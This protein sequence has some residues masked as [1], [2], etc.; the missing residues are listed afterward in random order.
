MGEMILDS[1]RV[2][3]GSV[4]TLFLLMGVGFFLGKRE[5]LSRQTLAQLSTLLLYIVS[6]AIMIDT[7][8]AE[9][10]NAPTLQQLLVA[11]AVLA[12]TYAL[13]MVLIPL[14]FRGAQ[15]EERG[16]LRF[17]AIYGNTSFMGV[18]L[19]L[20]VL[21]SQGMLVTVTCMAVFN[22]SIW[23]HGVYLMGGRGQLSVKKMFFN[24]G[25]I[26]FAVAIALF[27]LDVELPLPAA[28]T[29]GYIGSLNT[30][31]AMVVIG[32]QM[33]AVDLGSIFRE[34]RLYLASAVKLLAVP[35]VTMLVLLPFGLDSVTY[36][37]VV[38]L[39][40]C[41][42]AGATSLLCQLTGRDTA[43]SARLV[44]L[45]TLLCILTLP[46]VAVAAARLGGG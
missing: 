4:L 37:A 14:C 30:P 26:G 13:N 24:P 2:V 28:E 16:V 31:L 18:P 7:F 32:A 46:L 12:A 45:S 22:I 5:L 43:L 21:G 15:V 25:V 19:I 6:P 34:G 9:E 11:G 23:S 10:R 39:S 3:G 42:V 27:L 1:I 17:A 29:V 38:I 35:A 40:G 44:S 36:Q 8:L 41:P 20:S 33:S